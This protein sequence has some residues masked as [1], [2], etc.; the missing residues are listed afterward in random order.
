MKFDISNL[1]NVKILDRICDVYGFHQKIQLAN[2]FDIAASSLS[3]RYTR[4]SIS[5]DFAALCSIETGVDLRWILTGEGEKHPNTGTRDLDK[6]EFIKLEKFTISENK[7]VQIGEFGIDAS[8]MS[9]PVGKVFCVEADSTIYIV[10]ESNSVSDGEKLIDV[11]GTMSIREI[12]VLPGKK[13]HVTG[14]K[15]PFECSAEDIRV[16]GKVTGVFREAK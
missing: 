1:D 13:L 9:N 15:I 11:D 7:L 6:S 12:A 3:N 4:G 8:V 16:L 2:H 14:G 5:Y 10:E